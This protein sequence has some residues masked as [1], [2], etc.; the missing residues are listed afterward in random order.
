ME[1]PDLQMPTA[2][3][4]RPEA[5]EPKPD[6]Q[7]AKASVDLG[8]AKRPPSRKRSTDAQSICRSGRT[9]PP[10]HTPVPG[11]CP[12]TGPQEEAASEERP[13]LQMS[14][15]SVDRPDSDE[16][17]PDLQM[18]K[19]SVDLGEAER[20]LSHKRST[21][22]QSICRSGP[23]SRRRSKSTNA[24]NLY[25]LENQNA[26]P[27]DWGCALTNRVG[28]A[29]GGRAGSGVWWSWGS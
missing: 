5:D 2:S 11:V 13:D 3:V 9:P 25:I 26:H 12:G 28:A 24:T 29:P 19:A 14:K 7:T 1:R 8:E 10:A 4:D 27:G 17:K 18:P 22:A 20:P 16:P 21:D 15:A 23:T 6:L